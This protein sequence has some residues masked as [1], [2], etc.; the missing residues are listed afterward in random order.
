MFIDW[1]ANRPVDVYELNYSNE[2]V[3]NLYIYI[4]WMSHQMILILAT[5]ACQLEFIEMPAS[6]KML[7]NRAEFIKR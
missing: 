2:Y 4:K 7:Y 5:M 3:I 6:H 1:L